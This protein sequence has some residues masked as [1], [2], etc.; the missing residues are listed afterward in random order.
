MFIL[1]RCL[2]SH[3]N[4]YLFSSKQAIVVGPG[5]ETSPFA[6]SLNILQGCNNGTFL[7][8]LIK[9]KSSLQDLAQEVQICK[10]LATAL[11]VGQKTDF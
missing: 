9:L 2:W 4:L 8:V 6:M 10:P 11:V 5:S 7:P 1:W 3:N